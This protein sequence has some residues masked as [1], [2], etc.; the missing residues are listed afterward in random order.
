M[1]EDNNLIK[2]TS[3]VI[4]LLIFIMIVF[5]LVIAKSLYLV[6][7]ITSF[8]LILCMITPLKANEYVKSFKKYSF[9]LLILYII[10]IIISKEYRMLN[11]LFI[12]YKIIV[13]FILTKVF[14][15]NTSFDEMHEAIYGVLFPLRKFDLEKVSFDLLLSFS[16]LKIFFDS[17]IK[18]QELIKQKE[19][20]R[21]NIIKIFKI[22]IIDTVKNFESL[23]DR[24]KLNFYKVKY[25]KSNLKSKFILALS[26][27]FFIICIFKEVIL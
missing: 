14:A 22:R 23:Q 27:M 21:F 10:Y 7:F 25:K 12:G 6:L 5:S 17:K 19:I 11:M 8:V 1:L 9:V 15:K 3:P 20:N 18:V 4:R 13:I 24:L 16:L 2:G 26:I